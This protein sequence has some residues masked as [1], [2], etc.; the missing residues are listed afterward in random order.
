MAETI[1]RMF[2]DIQPTNGVSQ[3]RQCSERSSDHSKPAKVRLTGQLDAA[4][5]NACQKG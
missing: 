3:T 4:D 2:L 1:P 5:A